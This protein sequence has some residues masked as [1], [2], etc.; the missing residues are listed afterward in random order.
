MEKNKGVTV[1]KVLFIALILLSASNAWA[2]YKDQFRD[3]NAFATKVDEMPSRNQV[4]MDYTGTT[5]GVP[6]YV[7]YAAPSVATSA[8]T[9]RVCKYTDS[10]AGPTLKQCADD[11]NWDDR[12]TH[13]YS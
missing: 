2:G 7:G 13:T 9:W 3:Q 11:V 4:R 12:A 10:S 5:S 1:K 6:I 8:A